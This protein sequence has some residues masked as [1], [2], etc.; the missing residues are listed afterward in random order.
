VP[1]EADDRLFYCR[2]GGEGLTLPRPADEERRR[3]PAL[4]RREGGPENARV[5]E[6]EE[7]AR[8]E[9]LPE[10]GDRGDG[11]PL[12]RSMTSMRPP[13]RSERDERIRSGGRS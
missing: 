10:A 8:R 3:R 11:G 5:V 2:E 9:L 6:D 4:S 1:G 13:D 7:I 12:R